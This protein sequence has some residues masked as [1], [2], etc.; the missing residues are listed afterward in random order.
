MTYIT[1]EIITLCFHRYK[2][3]SSRLILKWYKISSIFVINRMRPQYGW[4]E[5]VK[6]QYLILLISFHFAISILLAG[7]VSLPTFYCH[8]NLVSWEGIC[9]MCVYLESAFTFPII[10]NIWVYL[11]LIK[12]IDRMPN[13]IICRFSI[14]L[15]IKHNQ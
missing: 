10:S 15:H 2:W 6:L 13:M 11:S 7:M 1:H 5:A 8:I 9:N 4:R 3:E 14:Q 12:M